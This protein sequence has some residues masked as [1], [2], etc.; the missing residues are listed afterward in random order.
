MKL[1][2][3]ENLSRKLPRHLADIYPNS[4]HVIT[5]G[6][7]HSD[8]GIVREFAKQNGFVLVTKDSDFAEYDRLMGSPPKT[9][10]IVRENAPT[11]EY[12]RLLRALREQI[13]AFDADPARSLLMLH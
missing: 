8:D 1:L 5:V 12:D 2:F 13:E 3:D 9:I 4:T 7:A 6:L 10:W 11:V